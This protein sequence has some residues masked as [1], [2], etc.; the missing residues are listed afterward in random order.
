MQEGRIVPERPAATGPTLWIVRNDSSARRLRLQD[1]EL[2]TVIGFETIVSQKVERIALADVERVDVLAP[3]ASPTPKLPL[4]IFGIALGMMLGSQFQPGP[5]LVIAATAITFAAVAQIV[6]GMT[7]ASR[8]IA[9]L[10]MTDGSDYAITYRHEDEDDIRRLFGR[11]QWN[12]SNMTA[13]TAPLLPSEVTH[14]ERMRF[15][16][17]LAAGAC[18]LIVLML[19]I[20]ED[21]GVSEAVAIP[22]NILYLSVL[23]L[24][25]IFSGVSWYKLTRAGM[26]R[27]DR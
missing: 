1:G 12:D 20:T 8:R 13:M 2:R 18:A 10:K 5:A 25:L 9:R 11:S 19:S 6:G 4:I 23:A 7:P 17:L 26:K 16:T 24:T 3:Y 14:A 15:G 21:S 22:V 27:G